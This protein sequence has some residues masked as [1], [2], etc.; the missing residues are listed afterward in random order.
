LGKIVAI[1]ITGSY[2]VPFF[3]HSMASYYN[4]VDEI[5]VGNGGYNYPHYTDDNVPL[6]DARQYMKEIDVN[7][8]IHEIRNLSY[9][10][11]NGLCLPERET[12]RA[13]AITA[14]S[15]AARK[16]N[17]DWILWAASDQVLYENAKHLTDIMKGGLGGGYDGYQFFEYKSFWG[18]PWFM[19]NNPDT[20]FSESDGVKFYRYGGSNG[21]RQ[22]WVGEGGI[23]HYRQQMPSDIVTAGHFRECAP[24]KEGKVDYDKIREYAEKRYCFYTFDHHMQKK[25]PITVKE[26]I[27]YGKNTAVSHVNRSRAANI[28]PADPQPPPVFRIG[29]EKYVRS[30][31][32]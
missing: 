13:V 12:R 24:A 6:E 18:S 8:K 7:G 32:P 16:Y 4:V 29:P 3:A 5:L 20:F 31:L 21:E 28:H 1:T 25:I 14:V 22:W 17:P 27:V 26:A 15:E 2:P 19:I 9:A 30:G 11:T 10:D 23:Q